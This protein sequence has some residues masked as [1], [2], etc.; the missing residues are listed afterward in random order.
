MGRDD[1]PADNSHA[2][3]DDAKVRVLHFANPS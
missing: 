3:Y 1:H 2:A